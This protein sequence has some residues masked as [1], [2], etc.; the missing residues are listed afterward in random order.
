MMR[1]TFFLSFVPDGRL[2]LRMAWDGMGW[3]GMG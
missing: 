2:L 3:D 1:D